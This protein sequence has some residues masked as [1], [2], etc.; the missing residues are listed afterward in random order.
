MVNSPENYDK[1]LREQ[2]W[3]KQKQPVHSDKT[4]MNGKEF[5]RK[6][7]KQYPRAIMH[8]GTH[9]LTCMVDGK[10]ID[11]WDCTDRKIGKWWTKC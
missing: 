5:V 1:Y 11:I 3:A 2:G 4:K 10:V 6:F 8:L 9:H 7:G